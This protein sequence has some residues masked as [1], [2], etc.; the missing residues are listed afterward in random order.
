MVC[1]PT[2]SNLRHILQLYI[3]QHKDLKMHVER[4]Y[5][6]EI[7]INTANV[8]AEGNMHSQSNAFS[9]VY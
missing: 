8:L 2:F 9:F 7:F 3:Y 1:Q 4:K 5:G 6:L